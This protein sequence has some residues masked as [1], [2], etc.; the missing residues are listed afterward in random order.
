MFLGIEIGGTKLQLGVGAGDGTIATLER[1]DVDRSRGAEGILAQI[2]KTGFELIARHDV[3]AVGIGFG[4]PIDSMQGRTVKSH[5]VAGWESFPLVEWTHSTLGLPAVLGNDADLAALAEAR[6]GAGRG[7]DPVFYVTVGT[8]IGGGLVIDGQVYR[9]S[10]WAASEI[11]HLR[12]GLDCEDAQQTVE[13][14]ASGPAIVAAAQRASQSIEQLTALRVAEA[15]ANGNA[16]AVSIF[17]KATRVLG[18]AIAQAITLTAPQVVVVGGGVALAGEELFYVPL[19]EAVDRYV[20]PSLRGHYEILAPL[21]GETVV[22]HGA[23]ALA[24]DQV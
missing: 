9:G 10:G 5:Q 20:F 1:L 14:I 22:V 11:G 15:A 4:G 19:R 2:A 3:R 16:V 12:P 21:L 24:A 18:W 6:F 23:L 7:R 17:R 8:G 13:A